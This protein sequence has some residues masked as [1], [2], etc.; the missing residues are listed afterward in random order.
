MFTLGDVLGD[1]QDAVRRVARSMT[2]KQDGEY[3]H[4]CCS[5]FDTTLRVQLWLH[6]REHWTLWMQHQALWTRIDTQ[7][8]L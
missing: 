5:W 4:H 8:W 2:K 6:D 3:G 7:I 1:G